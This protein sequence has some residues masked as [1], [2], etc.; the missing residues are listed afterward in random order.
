MI[1]AVVLS[2]HVIGLAVI[3][4]LGMMG[5]PIISVY[6]E[7]ND[8]GFVSKYV[9][10][11]VKA[12][13]PERD[14]EGFLRVL[15]EQG[16]PTLRRILMPADDATLT[17][18]SKNKKYLETC[19]IV[20]CVEPLIKEKFINKKYTYEIAEKIG[21]PSPRT[22]V[23]NSADDV[24]YYSKSIGFPCL[25]KPCQ[26]H[27]Y[28]ELFR[29]KM[30][31]VHNIDEAMLEFEKATNAGIEVML[32]ELIPGD[33]SRG[34]NYNSYVWNDEALV[35]FTAEKVRLSP[36]AFGV[37]RVVIS[38]DIPEII[39]PGRRIL[40]ALGFYGYSCTEFKKDARDGV[41]KLMEVNGRHN[42]SGMLAL[43]CGINF[44][45]I[46]Y[47]HLLGGD[48]QKPSKYEKGIFWIDEFND[49]YRSIQFAGKERY[50]LYD[51][52]RPYL[53]AHV[54]ATF[55]LDDPKPFFRRCFN[56]GKQALIKGKS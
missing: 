37:P 22:A 29:T 49:L 35:E 36:P 40:K 3:R 48:I 23:L 34:V 54:F 51:Y 15:M 1:P 56:L 11:R 4:A 21:I 5:V 28:F 7:E 9:R 44:P 33:D 27:L 19:Y 24:E 8:I 46:E 6:Y 26:S 13:H 10:E 14:E 12:P 47:C 32:Q 55:S 42:R 52:A 30:V 31:R 17:I 43:R 53:K 2:S 16:D 38:K 45:W 39:E 50:S 41:Y 20:A 25:I 18:V